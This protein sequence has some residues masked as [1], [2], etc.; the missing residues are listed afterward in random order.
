ME[1]LIPEAVLDIRYATTNNFMGIQVYDCAGC[2]LRLGAAKALARVQ[3]R[4]KAQGYGLILFDCYRPQ[5]A[6]HKLWAKTPDPRYVTPPAKGS[7]HSRGAAVDLSL[8]DSLGRELDMGTPFDYF[9]KEAYWEYTA[10]SPQV[11]RNRKILRQAMEA[12]G[13]KT[14]TTEWWHFN[15]SKGP[16]KLSDERWECK[17]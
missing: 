11:M 1:A 17:H 6:Q 9:G 7:M 10:H 14:V 13:F 5:Y 2:L 16:F 15:Y 4:V 8:V 12:E 3:A